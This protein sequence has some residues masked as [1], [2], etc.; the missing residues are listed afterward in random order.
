MPVQIIMP[1]GDKVGMVTS[2]CSEDGALFGGY[3]DGSILTF[4]IRSGRY[5]FSFGFALASSPC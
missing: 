1:V 4:D 5:S 3:E 2:L